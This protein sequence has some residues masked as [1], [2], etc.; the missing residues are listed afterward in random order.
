M[1]KQRHWKRMNSFQVLKTNL[2]DRVRMNDK[3]KRGETN[4]QAPVLSREDSTRPGA[5][6]L[7]LLRL[8]LS[9]PRASQ[10]LKNTSSFLFPT[11]FCFQRLFHSQIKFCCSV[12]AYNILN[13]TR[14]KRNM[15][16]TYD[17]DDDGM[18]VGMWTAMSSVLYLLQNTTH[19]IDSPVADAA[20]ADDVDEAHQRSLISSLELDL[21]KRRASCSG[22]RSSTAALYLTG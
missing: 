3:N 7:A 18:Y 17:D 11:L 5:S 1:N 12:L 9:Q 15:G 2:I 22:Q 20:A 6:R 14:H 8:N 13:V 21:W 4:E 16:T 19:L 10:A